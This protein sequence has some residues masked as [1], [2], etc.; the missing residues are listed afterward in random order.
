M[1]DGPRVGK[2]HYVPAA[3][4]LWKNPKQHNI[5]RKVQEAN[6]FNILK[7]G[8]AEIFGQ[9]LGISSGLEINKKFSEFRSSRN[10]L[11]VW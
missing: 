8:P 2:T 11:L 7:L 1:Y 3:T 6:S 10:C 5:V 4:L 9:D